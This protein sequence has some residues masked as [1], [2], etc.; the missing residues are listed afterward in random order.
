[1]TIRDLKEKAGRLGTKQG[2]FDSCLDSGKYVEQ[3]QEDLREGK[4]YGVNGTPALFLNGVPVEGGAVAYDV[5]ARLI[6]AELA[7]LESAPA[8]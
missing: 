1:M 2:D 5:I 4:R 3:V 7:R 6:D 8:N